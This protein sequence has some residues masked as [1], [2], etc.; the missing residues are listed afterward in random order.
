VFGTQADQ[1]LIPVHLLLTSGECLKGGIVLGL[2]SKLF[3]LMARPQAFIEFR[4]SDGTQQLVAKACIERV[5]PLEIP[6]ADQLSRRI[7]LDQTFDPYATLGI[8]PDAAPGEVSAA[9]RA[10]A[11]KYHP[12]HY[13]GLDAPHEVIDY[14]SAMFRRITLAYNELKMPATVKVRSDASQPVGTAAG[15]P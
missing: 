6:R 10:L 12:D 8:A 14:V 11:R 1:Q 7:A 9:Y 2:T 3:D 15:S 13:I 5:V 4:A